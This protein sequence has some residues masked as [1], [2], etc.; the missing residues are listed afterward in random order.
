[1]RRARIALLALAG[2]LLAAAG[3]LPP[4]YLVAENVQAADASL[5]GKIESAEMLPGKFANTTIRVTKVYRGL[6]KPGESVTY[7]SVRDDVAYDRRWREH[8]VI[9][10][11]TRRHDPGD[12][13]AWGTAIDFSEFGYSGALEKKVLRDLRQR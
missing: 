11:L 8:G 13:P 9:V 10:F 7:S 5:R 1:M 12:A 4:S 6:F 3:E 2:L